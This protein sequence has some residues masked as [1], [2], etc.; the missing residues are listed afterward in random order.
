MTSSLSDSEAGRRSVDV[1]LG[2][3]KDGGG[4]GGARLE[5]TKGIAAAP[6]TGGTRLVLLADGLGASELAGEA[7]SREVRLLVGDR[8]PCGRAEG[9]GGTA[10][11]DAAW[12]SIDRSLGGGS[13]SSDSEPD[14]GDMGGSVGGGGGTGR[15]MH[16]ISISSFSGTVGPTLSGRWRGYR[17]L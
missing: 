1:P 13:S 15:A 17:T 5:G 16:C 9:T 7:I 6:G 4:G 14:S 10:R 2:G 11:D 3:A 8:G 12:V